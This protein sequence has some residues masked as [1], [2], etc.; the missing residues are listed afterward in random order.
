MPRPNVSSA[1]IRLKRHS[2]TPV[3]VQDEKL[4]FTIIRAA[5]NQRRKTLQNSINNAPDLHI[6]KEKVL[7]AL[8]EMKLSPTVR[9]EALDLKQFARLA[10]LLKD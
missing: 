8:E 1:V 4:M 10:N 5:F 2:E 7:S 9:G 6:S 3:K